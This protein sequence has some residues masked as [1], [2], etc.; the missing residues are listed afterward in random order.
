MVHLLLNRNN[1]DVLL[2]RSHDAA[3]TFDAPVNITA[4]ATR[5]E[6]IW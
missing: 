5:P 4:A 2:L 1:R 3:R 6:W